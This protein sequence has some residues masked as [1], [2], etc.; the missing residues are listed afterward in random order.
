MSMSSLSRPIFICSLL[1][2]S[3]FCN[4][5]SKTDS[6]KNAG[7]GSCIQYA[8]KHQPAIQ[9]SYIDQEITERE[10]QSRLSLW[11]PQ[12]SLNYYL[13]HQFQL[14]TAYSNGS[15]FESGTYNASNIGFGATQAIFNQDVLLASR[16][17]RDVRLEA[18]QLTAENKIDIATSVGKAFYDVLLTE[19]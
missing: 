7:P 6:L 11:Y 1:S 4:A 5:Q 10:I 2:L 16:T 19:K 17:A 3:I 13:Q 18:K 8:L 15:F 14:P 9:Q 12:V